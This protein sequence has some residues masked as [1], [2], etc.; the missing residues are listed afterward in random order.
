MRVNSV[1]KFTSFITFNT[2]PFSTKT[3]PFVQRMDVVCREEHKGNTSSRALLRALQFST[4]FNTFKAYAIACVTVVKRMR[5][6]S[7]LN[8]SK[9]A[10]VWT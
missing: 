2:Q 10:L 3:K 7:A 8:A 4:P 5:H 6:S 9:S 1:Y